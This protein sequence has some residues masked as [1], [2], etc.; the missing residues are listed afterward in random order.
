MAWNKLLIAI[1]LPAMAMA[2]DYIIGDDSRW[3]IN[4]NYQAWA[5]DEVFYVVFQ[6]PKGYHNVFKV[7]GTAFKDC[8]IPPPSEVLTSGNDTVVLKTPCQKWYICGVDNH[9][10]AYGQKLSITV[11]Y[12]YGWA[13]APAPL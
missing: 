4:F 9:C 8:D 5:K 13:P 6:Y 3:T 12:Q 7:N 10:S 2:I 11:L 1:F